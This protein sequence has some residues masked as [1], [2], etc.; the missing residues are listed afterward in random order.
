MT[1]PQLSLIPRFR[2][3]NKDLMKVEF[4]G[5][6]LKPNMKMSQQALPARPDHVDTRVHPST[7]SGDEHFQPE[8]RIYT[9]KIRRRSGNRAC[10]R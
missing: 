3:L 6:S 2:E 7:D 8:S 10:L 9:K 1:L 4:H 5:L